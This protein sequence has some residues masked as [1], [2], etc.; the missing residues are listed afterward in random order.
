M[1]EISQ[2]VDEVKSEPIVE[3]IKTYKGNVYRYWNSNNVPAPLTKHKKSTDKE[4]MEVYIFVYICVKLS[5]LCIFQDLCTFR[6]FV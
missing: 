3:E 5:Y 6:D 4:L 2:N 1:D